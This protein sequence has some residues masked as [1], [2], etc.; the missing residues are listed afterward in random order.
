[1]PYR[2]ISQFEEKPYNRCVDCVHIGVHCDGPNFFAMDASR[3]SEWC[4][5]R[6]AYL[7]GKSSKWTNEYIAAEAD[8]SY[9]T[10]SKVMSGNIEDLR[11]STL[12]AIIRV[13]INGTWGQYP[14]ALAS[15]EIDYEPECKHLQELLDTER[16]KTAYLKKQVEFK[17]NQML[18]KDNTIRMLLSRQ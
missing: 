7:H 14:C 8:V 6:K 11:V 13:L 1:M 12:A 10:V 5:L 2:S 15:G 3:I 4:R 9:T 17:E 16:E 18:E